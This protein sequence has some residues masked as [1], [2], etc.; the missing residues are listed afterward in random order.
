MKGRKVEEP[1]RR[2]LGQ[3]AGESFIDDLIVQRLTEKKKCHIRMRPESLI[4]HSANCRS[5]P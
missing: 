4:L 2:D 1:R 3:C 5:A